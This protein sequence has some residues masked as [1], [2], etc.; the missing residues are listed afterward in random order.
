MI[1]AAPSLTSHLRS[2]DEIQLRMLMSCFDRFIVAMDSNSLLVG[3]FNGGQGRTYQF[4]AHS[5]RA[6]EL[7][8]S[9]GGRIGLPS[10]ISLRFLWT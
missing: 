2:L 9:R 3:C 6:Q 8:E 1:L 5:L 10:L 4:C 7:W